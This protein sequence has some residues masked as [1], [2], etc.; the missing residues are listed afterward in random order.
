MSK[1]K[2]PML[3]SEHM[4]NKLEDDQNM[5]QSDDEFEFEANSSP[6]VKGVFSHGHI[7]ESLVES[8]QDK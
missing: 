4:L 5:A 8:E 2:D 1:I 7:Q 6:Q 3:R